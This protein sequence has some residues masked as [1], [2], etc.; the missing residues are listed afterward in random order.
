MKKRTLALL[1]AGVLSLSLL[2]ACAGGGSSDDTSTPT[3]QVTETP[4]PTPTA[5][6]EPSP[7]PTETP[8]AES[9]PTAK[10]TA[11]PS[12]KPTP[13][14]TAKPTPKPTAKPTPTPAPTPTPTPESTPAPGDGSVDLA[15]FYDALV[16]S[17]GFQSMTLLEGD[18]LNSLYTGLSDISTEQCLV[19]SPMMTMNSGE[20]ALVQ[21]LDASDVDA[22]KAIFQSRIDYMAGTDD[23]PGGAWY[24]E[25]TRIWKEC[26]RITSNGNYVM[27]IVS[28]SADQAVSDF[29]ALF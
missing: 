23:A 19:Y 9:T 8:E 10:P 26:S 20:I 25:P 14:P 15:A 5:T 6:P 17:Y 27:L 16:A 4:S 11:T 13:K 28:E 1:L 24:P 22:V 21:V 12:P 18:G 29:N 2:S 3:P 7:E